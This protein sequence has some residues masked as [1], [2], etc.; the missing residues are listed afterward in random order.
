MPLRVLNDFLLVIPDEHEF[1][2]ENPEVARILKEGLIKLPEKFEGWFK[3]VPMSGKVISW[4]DKCRYQYQEGDRIIFARY[5]GANL[6]QDGKKYL[7]LKEHDLH[8]K[9]E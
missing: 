9:F 7:V 3:K 4:G 5:A 1:V 6:V 2:D 8:A